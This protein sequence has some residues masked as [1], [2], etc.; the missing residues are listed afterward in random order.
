LG[1][2]RRFIGVFAAKRKARFHAERQQ[3][4][5]AYIFG[6]MPQEANGVATSNSQTFAPDTIESRL[7]TASHGLVKVYNGSTIPDLTK[8]GLTMGEIYRFV[9]PCRTL[10]RRV[11]K[12]E[13]L[14]VEENDSALR[15][16][17]I[18]ELAARVFGEEA[19]ALR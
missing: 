12:G 3:L 8:F 7:Q 14:I 4:Q 5:F 15:A 18:F 6:Q 2:Y 10:A 1:H 9:A 17:R 13:P 19:K 16:V 11:P